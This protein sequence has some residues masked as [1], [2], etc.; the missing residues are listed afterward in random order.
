MFT[1]LA[2]TIL[3]PGPNFLHVLPQIRIPRQKLYIF[4]SWICLESQ[5]ATELI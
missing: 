4:A 1:M 2:F 3:H 5:E